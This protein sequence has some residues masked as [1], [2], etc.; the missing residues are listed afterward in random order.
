M[1]GY[2]PPTPLRQPALLLARLLELLLALG[3][4]L[5]LVPLLAWLLTRQPRK[6][7]GAR[8]TSAAA[9]LWGPRN[10]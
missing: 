4:V 10:R 9:V 2:I 8:T 7:A 1:I 6:L 3:L 5:L